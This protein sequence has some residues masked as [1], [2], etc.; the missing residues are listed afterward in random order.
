[1]VMWPLKS[2]TPP[3]PRQPVRTRIKKLPVYYE[4]LLD[5]VK[6]QMKDGKLRPDPGGAQE[7]KDPANIVNSNTSIVCPKC[8][9]DYLSDGFAL[10]FYASMI[11]E[12]KSGAKIDFEFVSKGSYAR[13]LRGLCPNKGCASRVATICWYGS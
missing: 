7:A 12:R 8:D 11:S 9:H 13:P 2:K 5:H 6:K 10:S 3:I 4:M 1:M